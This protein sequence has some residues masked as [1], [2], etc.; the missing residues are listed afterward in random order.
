MGILFPYSLITLFP[1]FPY[2]DADSMKKFL[3]ELAET[4]NKEHRQLDAMTVIFPNRRAVLYFRKHLSTFLEKPVFAPRLMTI[5]D[6]FASL[7]NL[8]V[9]DKLELNY[10]L[11]RA[12]K[13]IVLKQS[14]AAEPF[15]KFYFWGDMLLRDFDEIDKYL[16][17]A[18]QL[19]MDL[20]NQKELDSSFDYLTDEQRDFLKGFWKSFEENLTA[21]KKKFLNVWSHLHELYLAFKKSLLSEGLAYEGL[22]YRSVADGI[23]EVASRVK[24]NK[25]IFAGFNALTKTEE[26]VISYFIEKGHIILY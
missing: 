23:D 4:I 1:R 8:S 17:N 25:I 15:D 14:P 3:Y 7:T 9:P 10:R 12:Y 24:S 19:F 2:L 5:E 11:Y 21:N 6:F 16:V 18:G 13:E 20:S 26:K 22:M